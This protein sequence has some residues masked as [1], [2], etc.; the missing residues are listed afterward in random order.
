[1]K[2]LFLCFSVWILLIPKVQNP[3]IECNHE[4]IITDFLN[5]ISKSS[6][7]ANLSDYY[8]Y[9]DQESEIEIAFEVNFSRKYNNDS[10]LNRSCGKSYAISYI[11]NYPSVKK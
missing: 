10:L 11:M 4:K 7:V 3:K 8:K 1:M 2:N 6:Y 9:F 5:T